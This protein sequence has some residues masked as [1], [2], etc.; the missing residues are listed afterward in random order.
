MSGSCITVRQER[1]TSPVVAMLRWDEGE[2]KI[3]IFEKAAEYNLRQYLHTALSKRPFRIRRKQLS[4][5]RIELATEEVTPCD[6]DFL[7]QWAAKLT[8]NVLNR[9]DFIFTTSKNEHADSDEQNE[10]SELV[11]DLFE[12]SGTFRS[13]VIECPCGAQYRFLTA[14][15]PTCGGTDPVG[16]LLLL[17][18]ASILEAIRDRVHTDLASNSPLHQSLRAARG[19]FA[20]AAIAA[21]SSTMRP[22]E[23]D[24]GATVARKLLSYYESVFRLGCLNDE[25]ITALKISPGRETS[26]IT[27]TLRRT[28]LDIRRQWKS[29]CSTAWDSA[30]TFTTRCRAEFFKA[31]HPALRETGH[32]AQQMVRAAAQFGPF[33]RE[34]SKRVAENEDPFVNFLKGAWSVFKAVKTMGIS[35]LVRGA[36]ML[37]KDKKFQERFERF[38]SAFDEAVGSCAKAQKV[39]DQALQSHRKVLGR[40][41]KGMSYHLL[42]VFAE[43][44]AAAS[45]DE[46]EWLADKLAKIGRVSRLKRRSL[47]ARGIE[48]QGTRKFVL[49]CWVVGGIIL[50]LG[51]VMLMAV[52][53]HR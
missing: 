19:S 6:A 48:A 26:R 51:I 8:F 34:F 47:Q 12:L 2:P 50:I 20:G 46:Q 37:L 17:H 7:G 28:A 10:V 23:T 53:S 13:S 24:D 9:H 45:P 15:C 27:G 5:G 33:H 4:G 38:S 14:K 52:L 49:L 29:D 40:V 43:D 25:T 41:A 32:T 31:A 3:S 21:A 18:G 30:E 44:Y 35:L 36:M 16:A 1:L 39:I 42:A 11:S 22:Q